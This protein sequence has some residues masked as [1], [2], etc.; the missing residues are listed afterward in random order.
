MIKGLVFEGRKKPLDYREIE[1]PKYVTDDF[2]EVKVKAASINRRDY[3]ITKG[4]YPGIKKSVPTILG[5]DCSGT[6]EGRDCVVCPNTHDASFDYPNPSYG[7][8]GLQEYGCFAD[9]V[10]VRKEK[11]HSMPSH[12]SY[13]QASCL[14]LAGLTAYR[15]LFTK[16]N[17]EAGKKILISGV[18]GGVASIACQF[19]IAA[20]GSVYVTSGSQG[21]I[22]QA[23]SLGAISGVSY[24]NTDAMI[25]LAKEVGGFDLVI[26]SAGG[27]GFETLTRMCAP[28]ATI[29]IYG[30]TAG[31][32]SG[33]SVP[34]IFFKQLSIKGSTMGTDEEFKLMLDFVE[35]HMIVPAIHDVKAMKEAAASLVE[36]GE[37]VHFGKYVLINN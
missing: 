17:L 3:W 34:N 4:L 14:P 37:N 36:I 2:V 30:G 7:I 22:D 25:E 32:I 28:N 29:S 23:V 27:E 15:A 10:Y 5:S 35:E 24:K 21:K 16:G 19:A 6:Y 20:G 8:L 13:E 31:S 11:I 9:K 18:G 33:L 12:L 1:L 26:D